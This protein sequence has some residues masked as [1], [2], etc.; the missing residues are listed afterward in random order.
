MALQRT[1]LPDQTL[2]QR[3]MQ[4]DVQ[5]FGDLYERYLEE[6]QRYIF[7]RVSNRFD[8]EDL[9]ESTFLKAW[10][11]L[12]RFRSPEVNLRAWL[13]RIAHNTVIDHYR[14]R[15]PATQLHE[16]AHRYSDQPS[17][18][19]QAQVND[20]HRQLTAAIRTLDDRLQHTII[21]RFVC[22]LSH[23]ETAQV[24]GLTEQH[25]RVL[26]HRALNKLRQQLEIE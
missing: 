25:V 18:E 8:A 14:T 9:T 11:A 17:A 22:N 20:D 16:V 6:I 2:L 1:D 4:G 13:F 21:C 3:A 26:Q 12:P 15:K 19:E 23:A 5:A 24:M 7:Y 10:Q